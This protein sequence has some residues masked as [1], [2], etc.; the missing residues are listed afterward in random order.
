MAIREALNSRPK[1]VVAVCAVALV[2]LLCVLLRQL[3]VG[4]EVQRT[5]TASKAWYTTDN[6]VTWFAD[7]GEKIS[8]FDLDGKPAFRCV[9]WT[10][11]GG[12][13][14]FVSHLERLKPDVAKG[15]EGKSQQEGWSRL[16][17]LGLVDVKWLR[18]GD[19]GW[20]DIAAPLARHILTPK[21]PGTGGKP[22]RV[23][24]E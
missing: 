11:D 15:S 23:R 4:G 17:E 9:V 7:D 10:C 18:A 2:A 24:P 14:K 19:Q 6:G 20:V 16:R 13:T 12:E 5:A 22:Q 8:P 3:F 21:C 1:T